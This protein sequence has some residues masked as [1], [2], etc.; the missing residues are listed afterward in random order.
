LPYST[1]RSSNVIGTVEALRLAVRSGAQ[2]FH[3]VSTLSTCRAP[4]SS[5]GKPPTEDEWDDDGLRVVHASSMYDG[6]TMTKWMGEQ[7]LRK[8]AKTYGIHLFVYR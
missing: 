5:A 8:F 1:L 6:Y 4:V 3:H 7:I 2:R